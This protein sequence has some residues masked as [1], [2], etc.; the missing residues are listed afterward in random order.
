MLFTSSTLSVIVAPS[1][2]PPPRLG[3]T[4]SPPSRQTNVKSF[5]DRARLRSGPLSLWSPFMEAPHPTRTPTSMLLFCRP[6]SAFTRRPAGRFPRAANLLQRREREWKCTVK[7]SQGAQRQ[8]GGGLLCFS[9]PSCAKKDKRARRSDILREREGADFMLFCC[10]RRLEGEL[11]SLHP[12]SNKWGGW[13]ARGERQQGFLPAERLC[14][15]QPPFRSELQS[16]YGNAA[17]KPP[18]SSSSGQS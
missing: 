1:P 10:W 9:S 6:E 16:N 12:K 15:S 14:F 11:F 3:H 13:Q 4:P 17:L 2:V 8:E 5:V 7:N 18:F